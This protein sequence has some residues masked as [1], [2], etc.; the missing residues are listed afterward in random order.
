M[1]RAIYTHLVLEGHMSSVVT[2]L[3]DIYYE[4][5][6][7]SSRDKCDPTPDPDR[8][9]RNYKTRSA[10]WGRWGGSWNLAV[11]CIADREAALGQGHGPKT[12]GASTAQHAQGRRWEEQGSAG[13]G[14]RSKGLRAGMSSGCEDALGLPV[15]GRDRE[16]L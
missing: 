2:W 6:T 8:Q 16:V 1:G 9:G 10:A 7:V 13:L 14:S 15:R 3:Q 12:T 11:R 4:Q 5:G